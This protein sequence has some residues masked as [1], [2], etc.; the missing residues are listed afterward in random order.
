M[1]EI[2]DRIHE[3]TREIEGESV[4][5]LLTVIATKVCRLEA[6]VAEYKKAKDTLNDSLEY[7]ERQ[8]VLFQCL[9]KHAA[10][11]ADF[12]QRRKDWSGGTALPTE[13]TTDD[14]AAFL[15]AFE[16]SNNTG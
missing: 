7:Y 12:Y 9:C 16:M 4:T 2:D 14:R 10:P 8:M 6:E 11:I 15:Y 13:P 3:F 1:G 5:D